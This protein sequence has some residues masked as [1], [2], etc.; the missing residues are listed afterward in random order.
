[1]DRSIV[2]SGTVGHRLYTN[3]HCRVKCSQVRKPR[4]MV[5]REW[6]TGKCETKKTLLLGSGTINLPWQSTRTPKT[7]LQRSATDSLVKF[8]AWHTALLQ[9]LLR[10]LEKTAKRITPFLV[11]RIVI[12]ER[13]KILSTAG[14]RSWI[15]QYRYI[16]SVDRQHQLQFWHPAGTY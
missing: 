3:I 5:M 15:L 8:A 6:S 14:A 11:Y 13:N 9:T 4:P 7:F 1:M 12:V 10:V 2:Q 16:F